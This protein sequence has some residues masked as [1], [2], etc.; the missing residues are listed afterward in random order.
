MLEE[1]HAPGVE[2]TPG[3]GRFGVR[4]A[5]DFDDVY[6][7]RALPDRSSRYRRAVL[8]VKDAVKA[9]VLRRRQ[10]VTIAEFS[11]EVRTAHVVASRLRKTYGSEFVFRVHMD[12]DVKKV[13]CGWVGEL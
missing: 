11:S 10:L 7:E 4:G 13:L 8:S 6:D 3:A 2:G 12:G 1:A 5:V 9:G